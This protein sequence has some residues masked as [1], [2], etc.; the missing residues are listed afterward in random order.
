VNGTHS[1]FEETVK[2]SLSTGS[3]LDAHA[4]EEEE[5]KKLHG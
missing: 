3:F 2:Q 1:S 4:E 5:G